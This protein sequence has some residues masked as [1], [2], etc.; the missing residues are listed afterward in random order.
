MRALPKLAYLAAFLLLPLFGYA[1][2][3]QLGKDF[4]L[5][6]NPQ[7][8]TDKSKIDVVEFFSYGCPGCATIEPTL[9]VWLIT[10]PKDVEFSRIPAIFHAEWYPYAKA[11]YVAKNLNVANRITPDFFIAVHKE[12][13]PLNTKDALSFFFQKHKVKADDFAG[14]YDFSPSIDAQIARGDALMRQYGIYQIPTFVIN[15]TY[16]TDF[17]IAQGDPKRLMK[18]IDYLIAQQRV[19]PTAVKAA[20]TPSTTPT[21]KAPVATAAPAVK[22]PATAPTV[23]TPVTTPAAKPATKTP[24]TPAPVAKPASTT[25]VKAQ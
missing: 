21:A 18:I 2:E 13:Q 24:A 9:Q 10:K 23:K 3:F 5:V 22:A 14:N 16:Q 25:L 19:K 15:G 17:G 7:P 8:P 4:K 1:E 20:A 12:H 11:Y 6:S